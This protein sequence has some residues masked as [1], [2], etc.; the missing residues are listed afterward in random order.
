MSF[1][2]GW[3]GQRRGA[4]TLTFDDSVVSHLDNAAPI[5]DR[6][7]FRGT[8]YVLPGPDSLFEQHIDRWRKVYEAGHELGNHTV[9]HPCSRKHPFTAAD[10]ALEG[11]TLERICDDIDQATRRLGQLFTGAVS[12]TF[13]YPC[14][15]SFVGEGPS[16]ASYVPEV[17]RRF[18]AAR[19]VT[20]A[21]NDPVDCDLHHLA[22]WVVHDTG[23]EELIA[24]VQETVAAGGWGVFC[25]HGIGGDHLSVSVEALEGLLRYLREHE[26]EIWVDTVA[27][28]GTYLSTIRSGKQ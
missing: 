27:S 9:S 19:G 21:I 14:G 18:V 17:A 8:F 15:E 28:I 4:I 26:A 10:R 16:F 12:T 23:A 22:S 5:L 11:W 6:Y 25:F 13:A 3:P 24:L 7:G 1:F 2:P 20:W